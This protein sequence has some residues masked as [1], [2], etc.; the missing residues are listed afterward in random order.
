M[1]ALTAARPLNSMEPLP[2]EEE[3]TMKLYYFE[4]PNARKACAVAKHLGSPVEYVRVD[5]ASGENRTPDYLAINPNGKVPALENGEVK[6]WESPAIMCYLAHK[7]GS[8]LWPQNSASQI[9]AI[10]WLNWDTAHFSRHAGRLFWERYIKPTFGLGETNADEVEEAEGFFKQF[11]G[12]LNDHLKG[13]NYILGDKLS[14][15]D[16][17]VASFLPTAAQAELPLDGFDEIKR[18]HG[19]MMEIPA[20]AEPYPN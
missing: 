14:V 10:R 3:K 16:F 13:R 7:A 2:P 8:D 17:A 5:L 19:K 1:R 4:T 6:L 12:V 9:D 15:A 20:W 18:W 11:A